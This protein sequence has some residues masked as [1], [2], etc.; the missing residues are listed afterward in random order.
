M[1]QLD[2]EPNSLSVVGGFIT[3]A[4]PQ[5]KAGWALTLWVRPLEYVCEE[6][7]ET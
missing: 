4:H 5:T 7:Q 3:Y 2:C 1:G 6:L